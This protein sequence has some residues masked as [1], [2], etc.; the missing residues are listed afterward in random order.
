MSRSN[1]AGGCEAHSQVSCEF[2]IGAINF[3]SDGAI[4][5]HLIESTDENTFRIG[6]A[7]INS[8]KP[9]KVRQVIKFLDKDH[10][11]WVVSSRTAT[12]GSRSSTRPGSGRRGSQA[13]VPGQQLGANS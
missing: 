11:Q 2:F 13:L 3:A 9:P 4:S 10:F 7:A 1:T 6:F 8:D 5:E 12:S